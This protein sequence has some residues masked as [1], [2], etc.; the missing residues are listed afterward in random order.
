MNRAV[1][2]VAATCW[3]F[4]WGLFLTFLAAVIVVKGDLRGALLL[5]PAAW[6]LMVAVVRVVRD[7]TEDK[8]AVPSD[9]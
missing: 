3:L 2:S 7:H 8:A 9:R 6:A 5:L 4:L 1:L